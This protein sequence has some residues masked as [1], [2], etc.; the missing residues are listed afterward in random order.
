MHVSG[1][2]THTGN[3]LERWGGGRRCSLA[4]VA[5]DGPPPSGRFEKAAYSA[6]SCL[7]SAAF[8]ASVVVAG[9]F[10]S[11]SSSAARL[12]HSELS[13]L[14]GCVQYHSRIALA[15]AV[16]LSRVHVGFSAFPGSLQ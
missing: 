12:H 14:P 8:A 9:I 7:R 15:D 13:A 2:G 6:V 10:C 11:F 1:V 4:A 5:R 3:G 16:V